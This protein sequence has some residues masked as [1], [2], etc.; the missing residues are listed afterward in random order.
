MNDKGKGTAEI[1]GKLSKAQRLV[2]LLRRILEE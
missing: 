2:K 1:S